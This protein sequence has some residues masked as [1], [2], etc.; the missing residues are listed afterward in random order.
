MFAAQ[1]GPSQVQVIHAGLECG[2]I[3]G[4]YPEFDMVSFGPTIQGAHA[5]GERVDVASVDRCWALLAAL[6]DELAR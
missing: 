3:G 5:P 4:I 6:L 1:Y 2:I